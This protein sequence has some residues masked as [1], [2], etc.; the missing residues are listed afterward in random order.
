MKSQT[1]L[2]ALALALFI[3]PFVP[4][5]TG[6]ASK[7]WL[8]WRGPNQNGTTLETGLPDNIDPKR[9][10][11]VADYPGQSCPVVANG[12]VYI[13]GYLG[14]GPELQE[15]VA[16]FDAETGKKLWEQ[17]Y[18]DYLSDTIYLRYATSSAAVDA[19]TGNIYMQGTQ[20][21]LAGFNPEGK[22]LW[23]L[24][25]MEAFGRLTFPNSRTASPLIDGDLVITRGITANWGAQGPAGDRFYAFDK[26]TGELVW[27][28]SP[29]DRPKD[30]SFSHPYLSW[31]NGKR[32]F[33]AATGDGSIVCVNAR[34]GEPIWRI[35]IFRA[36]INSTLLVHNN[37]KIISIFGTPYEPGQMVA[38]KIPTSMPANA[39]AAPVVVERSS[40]ELWANELS[41]STS[42]PILVG[43]RVYV[44]TEK[45]D[46]SA[47]DATSGK[48]MWRLKLGIEERNASPIYA[49]GKLY[50]PMLDEFDSKSEGQSSESGS[51]GALYI[52]KPGDK[53]GEELAHVV[54]D[55]RC[56][57]TPTAYNGKVYIQ[58]TRHLYAFGKQGNNPG[59][60]EESETK[61]WPK[62]GPV[63]QL[64]II[65][66]EVLMRPGQTETF[67]VRTLDANGFTVAEVKDEKAVKW[68]SYIP[69][70]A[71][72]KATM[73][74]TF[75]DQGKLV[76]D[77]AAVPSA[78][79]FEA[80]YNGVKGYIRGRILPYL[81]IKQDFESFQLTET[82]AA[83]N[84]AFSYPP[85]PWIGARFKFEVREKDGTKALTKTIDNRFFQ[86]ATVFI[87]AA[88][89]NNYTIEADVMSDGN[90]RK[91]SDVGIINQ[92]YLIV[93]K[94]NE[95]KLEINSNLERLRVPAGGDP[96]NFKWSPNTWYHLKAR[97]DV[98]QNG[99]GVVRAK[100]WKKSEQEPEKWTMEVPHK[101]AHQ[102]GSPGLFGFSPQ[103]MRVYIDNVIVSPNN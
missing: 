72:V 43:D 82:N 86:R 32:V 28:S 85:L 64:Q 59:L 12:K 58:T 16:C 71:K 37:D 15:G 4:S 63:A 48:I 60:P 39:A 100:A 33:F 78:G 10:L 18:S 47:V 50:V 21:I 57:G 30:N 96:S 55:G 45:G 22:E 24:S 76:A 70:T 81:P 7:G 103:D 77:K 11:W 8:D 6:A 51:R 52:I 102:S 40:V 99:E 14:E 54:L 89:A 62:P 73:K 91:M 3:T 36:G 29:G 56:F 74:G 97:V 27:S 35:P 34:T 44:V 23:K 41:T 95:Q 1:F 26:K 2:G 49:D 20:G 42:S 80:T 13:M 65:P 90:K 98:G 46:L 88:Q 83:E 92:H 53:A 25:L 9:P 19:E 61:P 93:L 17:R 75:D 66:S 84:A 5:P 101:H 68:A 67:R 31:L 38:L 87:G 79:A 94:G 69:P